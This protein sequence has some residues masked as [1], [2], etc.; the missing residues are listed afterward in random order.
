ML[1]LIVFQCDVCVSI[2]LCVDISKM[3][4]DESKEKGSKNKRH[5]F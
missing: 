2:C 5:F 4:I 1:F 3:M